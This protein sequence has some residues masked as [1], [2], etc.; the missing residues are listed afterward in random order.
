[1]F[2]RRYNQFIALVLLLSACLSTEV[3]EQWCNGAIRAEI[4]GR[5]G[6]VFVN[7][8]NAKGNGFT[9]FGVSEQ[10]SSATHVTVAD[11]DSSVIDIPLFCFSHDPPFLV[12]PAI[13][14]RVVVTT[15]KPIAHTIETRGPPQPPVA[16]VILTLRAPP[17]A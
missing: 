10:V 12:P 14:S 17:A 4:I 2:N 3:A 15:A 1:M 16:F 6:S 5:C 11:S 7:H 13:G 9:Q 8:L